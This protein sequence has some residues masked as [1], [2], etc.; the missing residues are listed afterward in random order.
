VGERAGLFSYLNE[1]E[2]IKLIDALFLAD[3]ASETLLEVPEQQLAPLLMKLDR[4]KV[5]ALL[6][7][8]P[9]DEAAYFLSLLAENEKSDLLQHLDSQRQSKLN[10]ILSFAEDSAG[11]L[12]SPDVF[13]LPMNLTASEGLEIL[14]TKAQEESVYYIYCVNQERQLTGVVSLRELATSPLDTRLTDLIHRDVVTVKPDTSTDEVARLVSRYGFVAIPVVN[15]QN[16]L[17]GI[18]TIDDV[19]DIIQEQATANL[20]ASAGLQH[21]DRVYTPAWASFR[22]RVPW[23]F[24]NLF[25]AG[26]ASSVISLFEKTMT[27]L[28]VLATLKNIVAGMGG[29]TA[30]QSLTVVT[31]GIAT[32][33]FHYISRGR[34]VLK[35]LYVGSGIG[36]ITGLGAAILVYFWKGT[37][38][39]SGVI[40]MSMFLNSLLAALVGATVPMVLN[41]YGWDPAVGSGVIVTMATDIFGFLSFLGIATLALSY[42]GVM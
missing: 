4:S 32:D 29:N 39:V 1:G 20:Y 14:R 3:L 40:F 9:E 34:A 38:L 18:I 8:S 27:E 31:R 6:K 16:R 12:M 2:R 22:N 33:D 35:E 15:D 10:Q 25:L 7:Y 21:D 30:I 23:M 11:R 17:L 36:L 13:S 37:L 19:V 41:K 5:L 42:F 24:L 26:A 28:I